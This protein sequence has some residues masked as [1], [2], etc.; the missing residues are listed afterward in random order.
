MTTGIPMDDPFYRAPPPIV[1]VEY[2]NPFY[3]TNPT[4]GLEI[5]DPL[6]GKG[7]RESG[8]NG[9]KVLQDST[10]KKTYL[11]Q[12]SQDPAEETS[13]QTFV[14]TRERDN[15]KRYTVV[16]RWIRC[17]PRLC[18]KVKNP[19]DS[20][21]PCGWRLLI[22]AK[23][24]GWKEG[25]GLKA[26]TEGWKNDVNPF[27]MDYKGDAVGDWDFDTL[28]GVLWRKQISSGKQEQVQYS[29]VPVKGGWIGRW[30]GIQ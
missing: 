30:P 4:Q 5:T 26:E 16:W 22:D 2:G 1:D 14:D 19:E 12:N 8:I 27:A 15:W 29:Q 10:T 18:G 9:S 17:G 23:P 11:W 28:N 21:C 25:D 7:V 24:P 13:Y 3:F 6:V 20:T